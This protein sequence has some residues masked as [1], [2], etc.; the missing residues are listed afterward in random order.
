MPAV[1]LTV[2]TELAKAAEQVKVTP[3]VLGAVTAQALPAPAVESKAMPVPDNVMAIPALAAAVMV[4][5]G[6]NEIVAVVAVALT[7]EASVV[8]RPLMTDAS[9]PPELTPADAI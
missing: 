4:C 9:I 2:N 7:V 5:V 1:S 6:V 3:A 8:L